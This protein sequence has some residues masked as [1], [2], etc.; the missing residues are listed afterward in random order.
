MGQPSPEKQRQNVPGHFFNVI[1]DNGVIVFIDG[2]TGKAKPDGWDQYY[3]MRTGWNR[4]MAA[5]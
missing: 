1:N 5:T 3:L 2:Q 4:C